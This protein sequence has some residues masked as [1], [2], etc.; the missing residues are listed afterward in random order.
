MPV[1]HIQKRFAGGAHSNVAPEK[2]MLPPD[3]VDPLPP[4]EQW[5]DEYMA[6]PTETYP[7]G[8]D[9]GL[10]LKN[11]Y[12]YDDKPQPKMFPSADENMRMWQEIHV[13][14]M[15][16]H[17]PAH[18]IHAKDLPDYHFWP[19]IQNDINAKYTGQVPQLVQYQYHADQCEIPRFHKNGVP[20]TPPQEQMWYTPLDSNGRCDWRAVMARWAGSQSHGWMSTRGW[21]DRYYRW[22]YIDSLFSWRNSLKLL[23]VHKPLWFRHRETDH[24]IRQV[25]QKRGTLIATPLHFIAVYFA[26][27]GGIGASNASYKDLCWN[28]E[29]WNYDMHYVKYFRNNGS[30]HAPI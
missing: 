9:S 24:V 18:E 6:K 13:E 3:G 8:Y 20:K 25:R 16:D 4:Q 22:A 26:L 30:Y 7:A 11:W 10:K 17:Q 1:Y 23:N 27:L 2:I 29:P 14:R 21:N 19:M 28:D 12:N 5:L 15:L